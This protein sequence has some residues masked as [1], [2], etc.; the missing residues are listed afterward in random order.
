MFMVALFSISLQSG[1]S[2]SRSVYSRFRARSGASRILDRRTGYSASDLAPGRRCF[3]NAIC[4]VCASAHVAAAFG[5]WCFLHVLV[6]N[7]GYS[8]GQRQ[9]LRDQN[10]HLGAR[11]VDFRFLALHWVW[12]GRV[13]LEP[14]PPGWTPGTL[15]LVLLP[16]T[17]ASWALH[18]KRSR[19]RRGDGSVKVCALR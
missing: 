18:Y 16:R 8:R 5:V 6:P 17:T 10:P 1:C 3:K 2:T 4:P 13:G 15:T 14:P 7:R 12:G 11:S 19:H 9:Y